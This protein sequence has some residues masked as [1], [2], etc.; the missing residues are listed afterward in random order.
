MT[1]SFRKLFE[2]LI[3]TDELIEEFLLESSMTPFANYDFL[4]VAGL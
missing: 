4:A 3:L 1:K 2:S